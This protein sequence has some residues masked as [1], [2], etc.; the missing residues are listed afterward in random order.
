MAV[1]VA[2]MTTATTA[3]LKMSAVLAH[4]FGILILYYV[5]T[6]FAITIFPDE[7]FAA[8]PFNFFILTL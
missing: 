6:T 7:K 4:I 8:I 1:V 2:A 3:S 5:A